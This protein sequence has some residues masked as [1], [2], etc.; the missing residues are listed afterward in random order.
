MECL[1]KDH[2]YNIM[3]VRNVFGK[4]SEKTMLFVNAHVLTS[5]LSTARRCFVLKLPIIFMIAH[6]VT[7]G[8]AN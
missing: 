1:V 4:Q 2:Q 6:A 8:P 5:I 7:H 3:Y